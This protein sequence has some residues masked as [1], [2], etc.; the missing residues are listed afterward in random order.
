VKN[1]SKFF[2]G[3]YHHQKRTQ[4]PQ[5]GFQRRKLKVRSLEPV[6]KLEILGVFVI[7]PIEVRMQEKEDV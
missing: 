5:N 6:V 3:V 7:Q 2:F 4:M 1:G